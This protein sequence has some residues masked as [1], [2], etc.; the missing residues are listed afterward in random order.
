MCVTNYKA[1][2]LK[3]NLVIPYVVGTQTLEHMNSTNMGIHRGQT[4]CLDM[5]YLITIYSQVDM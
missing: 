2:L 5:S 1:M 4:N 3:Y